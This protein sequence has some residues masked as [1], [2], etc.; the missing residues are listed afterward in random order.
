[1]VHHDVV[2]AALSETTTRDD[3]TA[4]LATILATADENGVDLD[5]TLTEHDRRALE[6]EFAFSFSLFGGATEQ[7]D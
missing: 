5:S 2:S 4:A 7:D 3:L 6:S 1:M